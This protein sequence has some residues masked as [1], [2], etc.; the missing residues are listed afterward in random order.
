VGLRTVLSR[1]TVGNPYYPNSGST[2]S[3]GVTLTPPYSLFDGKKYEGTS[4]SAEDRYRWIEYHKWELS[5]DWYFPLTYNQKLVLRTHAEFGMIGSYNKN[6]QSPFEGFEVGGDGMSGYNL[7][8]VDVIGLRGYD[9]GSLS[10]SNGQS[11]AYNK[12]TIELRYPFVQQGQTIIFGMLFA[13]GGNAFD[14]VR[15]FDPFLIKRSL[16]AGLRLFLPMV[17]WIGIDYAYGFDRDRSGQK[18]G[19]KPHFVIGQNF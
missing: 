7:Y 10:P 2:F 5:A 18:G 13:E 6:K 15:N 14:N 1:N 4:L 16:G 11:K 9:N 12:Y 8:G 17:G 3:L 19:G